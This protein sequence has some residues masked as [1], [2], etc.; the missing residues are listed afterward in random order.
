LG[1]PLGFWRGPRVILLPLFGAA[2]GVVGAL[3]YTGSTKTL[4]I[5]AIELVIAALWGVLAFPYER[6]SFGAVGAIV[7]AA[8]IAARWFALEALVPGRVLE[9][10]IAAQTVPRVAIIALAW[11]SRPAGTGIVYEFSSRLTTPVALIAMALGTAAAL[12]CGLRPGAMIL[13]GAYLII[14][15]V[16]WFSYRYFGGVNANSFAATQ[17]L[18]EMFVLVMFTCAV[19]RW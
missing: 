16:R 6:R 18:T 7:I 15:G 12:L 1:L 10:F 13:V 2:I 11:V 19:C 4:P 3:V 9:L 17:L 14:R 5:S 8:S